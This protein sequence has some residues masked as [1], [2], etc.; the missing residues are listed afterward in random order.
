MS[1]LPKTVAKSSKLPNAPLAEVVFELRWKLA[2]DD[3]GAPN[4]LADPGYRGC[5]DSFFGAAARLGYVVAKRV[6]PSPFEMGHSVDYRFYKAPDIRFPV[7]QL[8][9]GIFAANES[10]GY[11]W[12]EYKTC[13]LDGIRALLGA[14]P[15]MKRFEFQPSQIQLK[16]ID[17][18]KLRD[19]KSAD[20]LE[21][22]RVSTNI[23]VSIPDFL[24]DHRFGATESG[25]VEM[26]FPVSDMKQT[27]FAFAMANGI[28]SDVQCI[29]LETMVTT[30]FPE[31]RKAK[32]GVDSVGA[33]LERAH[34]LT[35]PFF[36]SVVKSSLMSEFLGDKRE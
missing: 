21:F 31:N 15:K 29:V 14:Y 5:L 17:A 12:T 32:F 30:K 26:A 2:A 9:P 22:L 13:C 36:K 3:G 33:W 20:Y 7:L 10:T 25:R 27:S 24:R 28:V 6:S 34:D 1:R 16:Y 11:S 23:D 8:G 18:L 4:I 19:G 35:S